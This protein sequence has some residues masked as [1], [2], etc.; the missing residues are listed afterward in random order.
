MNLKTIFI[1]TVI[2][3][4]EKRIPIVRV[5]KYYMFIKIINLKH[6]FL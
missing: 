4:K 6:Q 1:E 3:K 2:K 5:F